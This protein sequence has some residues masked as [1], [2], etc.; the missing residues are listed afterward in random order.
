[1]IHKQMSTGRLSRA[2]NFRAKEKDT[3]LCLAFLVS[4]WLS[5]FSVSAWRNAKSE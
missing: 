2:G 1:M 3:A 4:D 5:E